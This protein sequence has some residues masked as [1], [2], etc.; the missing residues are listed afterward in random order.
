MDSGKA[1]AVTIRYAQPGYLQ[2]QLIRFIARSGYSSGVQCSNALSH[3][4]RAGRKQL[5]QQVVAAGELHV[6]TNVQSG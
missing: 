4:L 5:F 6:T 3:G 2:A 1:F